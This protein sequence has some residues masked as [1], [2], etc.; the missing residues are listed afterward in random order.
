M[1]GEAGGVELHEGHVGSRAAGPESHG[2]AVAGAGGR[3]GGACVDLAA[4]AAGQ[5]D[6]CGPHRLQLP[7]VQHAHAHA[8]I[9]VV[10]QQV[11]GHGLFQ[12]TDV[13]A[14]GHGPVERLHDREPGV[15]GHVGDAAGT[16][17]TFACQVQAASIRAA[18]GHARADQPFDGGTSLRED[19]TYRCLVA[20]PGTGHQ[21]VGHMVIQSVKPIQHGGD[22]ALRATA[23]VVIKPVL[24]QQ[25]DAQA[26]RQ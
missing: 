25:R 22:T 17:P 2:N 23:G 3:G 26:L 5:H 14:A 6:G 20:Q 9:L 15:V 13:G 12:L 10:L 24:A 16:V 11:H 4:T 8:A 1:P 7:L 18:E 21:R 19:G